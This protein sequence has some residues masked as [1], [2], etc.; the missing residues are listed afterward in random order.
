MTW[1]WLK[2][3]NWSKDYCLT[4]LT[5][6][7]YT[8]FKILKSILNVILNFSKSLATNQTLVFPKK[9]PWEHLHWSP[10][11]MIGDVFFLVVWRPGRHSNPSEPSCRVLPLF[12]RLAE[13]EVIPRVG[14][15][16][17]G[18]L[19]KSPGPISSKLICV[20]FLWDAFIFF[21]G[22]WYDYTI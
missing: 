12:S 16:A 5:I 18:V 7:S 9:G 2:E 19:E 22:F 4:M 15:L 10:K 6:L 1:H 14:S 20:L 11:R 8:P 13:P 3:L 17:V 21:F